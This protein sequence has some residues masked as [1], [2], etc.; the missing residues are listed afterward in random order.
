MANQN[1]YS[2]VTPRSAPVHQAAREAQEHCERGE[3]WMADQGR[4]MRDDEMPAG[5]RK[6]EK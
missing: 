1:D 6:E 5:G 4:C 2:A 3:H